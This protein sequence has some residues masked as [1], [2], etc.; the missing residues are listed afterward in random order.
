MHFSED[1]HLGWMAFWWILTAA[2]AVVTL[3]Y[4]RRLRR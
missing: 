4:V 3:W 2:G 1:P